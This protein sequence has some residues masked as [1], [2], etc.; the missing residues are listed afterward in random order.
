MPLVTSTEMFKKAYDGGYAIGA[1]RK[2]FSTVKNL[3]CRARRPNR[4]VKNY[5]E[6][7][8]G[9]ISESARHRG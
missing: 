2:F 9:E 6:A 5:E 7:G 8:A 4:I 3:L 1:Y